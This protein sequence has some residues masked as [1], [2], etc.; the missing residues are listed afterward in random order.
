LLLASVIENRVIA[1]CQM[2]GK[3]GE[4]PFFYFSFLLGLPCFSAGMGEPV[5]RHH[6]SEYIVFQAN[7]MIFFIL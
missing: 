2:S 7:H 5:R 4:N 1:Q 3:A 6:I